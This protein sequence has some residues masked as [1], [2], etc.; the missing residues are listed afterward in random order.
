MAWNPQQ[1]VIPLH[2][3]DW[4]GPLQC[5]DRDLSGAHSAYLQTLEQVADRHFP[6]LF[7]RLSRQPGGFWLEKD[8]FFAVPDQWPGH[9]P[10]SDDPSIQPS[11]G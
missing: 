1:P 7:A 5:L 2:K 6:A 9:H 8:R 10:G 3:P 11:A 4:L